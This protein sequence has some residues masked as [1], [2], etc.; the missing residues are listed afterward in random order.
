MMNSTT[1]LDSEEKLIGI[2]RG[3]RLVILFVGNISRGDDGAPQLLFRNIRRK[4]ARIKLLD[5]GT[6][7]QDCVE[8]VAKIEPDIVI[9]VNAIDRSLA[10]GA[11]VLEELQATY[12]TDSSLVSHKFPLAWVAALIKITCRRQDPPIRTI[13]MGIQIGSTK[14]RTTIPVRKS[15]NRLMGVFKKM[16]SNV[17][18][19][20]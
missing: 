7:P 2:V 10:P 17:V 8:V 6:S 20:P 5:C 13:L 1:S 3:K 4:A 11:I 9:F 14:G 19:F 12:S 15:V 16:D 18:S